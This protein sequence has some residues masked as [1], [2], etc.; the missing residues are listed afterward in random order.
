M[1]CWETIEWP[2][3][4]GLSSSAQLHIVS[5]YILTD[6]HATQAEGSRSLTR[7]NAADTPP[8]H[9]F[10]A[11]WFPTKL[12]SH[13]ILPH[14]LHGLG[15]N[16]ASNRNE[17]QQSSWELRAAGVWGWSHCHLSADFLG[18]ITA[19]GACYRDSLTFLLLLLFG[20]VYEMAIRLPSFS[21]VVMNA[22]N[23]TSTNR[24]TKTK[25]RGLSPQAN[26]TDWGEISAII[27]G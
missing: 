25:L 19:F 3:S 21:V 15:V 2:T 6:S 26:Y 10:T 14:A 17:Y 23:V 20:K 27:C 12:S 16:S 8:M 13:L 18:S 22:W 7:K 5:Y 1:K 9:T 11:S 24:K 4:S